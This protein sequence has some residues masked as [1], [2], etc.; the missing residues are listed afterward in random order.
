M[1]VAPAIT[2][3]RATPEDAPRCGEICYEAFAAIN[4]AHG[5]PPDFPNPEIASGLLSMLFAHPGFYAIVADADGRPVGSNALDERNPISGVGPITVDP[6]AQNHGIGRR[7]MDAVLQRSDERKFRGVRLV[8]AAFHNRSL[9]LYTKLG[10]DAVEP[11]S[12][13]NGTLT[14]GVPS[15]HGVR[16]ATEGDVDACNALCTEVHG[17]DRAGELKDAIHQGAALVV[18]R[19]NAVT[20]YATG[21]GYFGHAVGKDNSDLQALI[22]RATQVMGPGML[23]PTRNA[24]LFRWC[25]NNGL[26]VLFPMTLMAKGYYQEP[27]GSYLPSIL[28]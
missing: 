5:F 12:V 3:R 10:F 2:V 26:R 22:A 4:R 20:G 11:L 13:M 16:K 19:D 23:I 7:L 15:G 1:A 8:Q 25:L 27:S 18:E 9:S 6:G 24:A 14:C 28:Y 17:H 21:F